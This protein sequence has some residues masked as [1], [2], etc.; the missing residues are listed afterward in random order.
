MATLRR[1]AD[2][3]P[4]LTNLAQT[5][6]FQVLFSGLPGTLTGYLGS[7][8]VDSRFINETA[9]LLCYSASLPG[10]SFAT[11]DIV[12]NY[13]G[14]AEK[15]AH[16]RQFTQI[17]LEFYVDRE[18]KTIKFLEHW[19]EFIA[20]GSNAPQY[21]DGYYFRMQYPKSYKS[22]QTRILKFD[23]DYNAEI[24][25]NFRGLFPYALGGINI[26]YSNSD[27]LKASA[28][29]SFERYIAGQTSSLSSYQGL[30]NNLQRLQSTLI[31]PFSN[32]LDPIGSR[33]TALATGRDELINR[34]LNLGTGRLDDSRPIGI[35]GAND[36]R[37]GLS[38]G[39]VNNGGT[40]GGNVIGTRVI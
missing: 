26:N 23:R 17:D 13:M 39:L 12:G 34:N 32:I 22:D 18:Y 28:T 15:M 21:S 9:G 3:K 27:I 33:N 31:D 5:S 37:G 40:S 36:L 24:E 35:R 7:R 10:S 16:T 38:G 19:M 29:F 11:S 1:I 4:T 6:H 20:S 8:G 25:Y 30:D 2:F 14:I